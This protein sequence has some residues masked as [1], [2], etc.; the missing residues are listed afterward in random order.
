MVGSSFTDKNCI[1]REIDSGFKG[2]VVERTTFPTYVRNVFSV[3][4]T[5]AAQRA[6]CEQA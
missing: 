2:D 6:A 4:A 3:A 5:V 1:L